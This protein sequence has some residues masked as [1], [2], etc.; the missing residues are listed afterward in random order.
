[1]GKKKKKKKK[2][3]FF[4]PSYKM[5][6]NYFPFYIPLIT[7]LFIIGINKRINRSFSSVHLA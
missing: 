5:I 3:N 7:N 2:I 6:I 4:S 1:M